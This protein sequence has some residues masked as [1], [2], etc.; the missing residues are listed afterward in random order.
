MKPE[1]EELLSTAEVSELA[2]R[3]LDM[4][5]SSDRARAAIVHA[6]RTELAS[7]TAQPANKTVQL[8]G[9]EARAEAGELRAHIHELAREIRNLPLLEDFKQEDLYDECGLPR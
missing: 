8:S 7:E 1:L 4:Y 9:A 3:F 6:L 2:Q 5:G